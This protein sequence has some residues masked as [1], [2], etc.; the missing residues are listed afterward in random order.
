MSSTF[1]YAGNGANG[2]S[3]TSE[4]IAGSVQRAVDRV[5]A[6][7]GGVEHDLRRRVAA[8]RSEAREQE[9]RARAMVSANIQKALDYTREKPLVVAVGIAFAAAA[10]VYGLLRRR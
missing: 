4:R 1:S 10:V 3:S 2:T 6:R 7:A 5:A 8:L 9:Q